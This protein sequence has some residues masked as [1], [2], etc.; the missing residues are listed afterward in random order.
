MFTI[1]LEIINLFVTRIFRQRWS[2]WPS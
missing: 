2:S 1:T